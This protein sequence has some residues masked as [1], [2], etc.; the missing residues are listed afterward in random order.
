[1][2]RSRRT[3]GTHFYKAFSAVLTCVG[4]GSTL[5]S[6]F[7]KGIR[8]HFLEV[9]STERT[10]VELGPEESPVGVER[11]VSSPGNTFVHSYLQVSFDGHVT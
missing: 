5:G 10:S 8:Q 2:L 9:F 6:I 4:T 7:F 1:M 3:H 11:T